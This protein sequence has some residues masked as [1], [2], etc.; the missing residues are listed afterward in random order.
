LAPDPQDRAV[1]LRDVS[2]A[3]PGRTRFSLHVPDFAISRGERVFLL[4]ESGSGKSTLLSLICGIVQ[5]GRGAVLVDGTDLTALSGPKR[6][7]LRANRIGV[8]FQMFNLLPYA[9]PLENILL[10]LAFA[11]E[12]RA[13]VPDPEAEALRLTAALGL[14]P[15]PMR[16]ARAAELSIGQQQRVA[17]ARA[18]IGGPHLVIADEPTS[19]LDATAQG[20]FVDLLMAQVSAAGAT[21]LMVSHDARLADRF[22]RVVDMRDIATPPRVAA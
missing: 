15:G 4:G 1:W 10:A 12:R 16:G 2:F 9:S 19:A 18:L 6:D 21:L 17:A 14:E 11:P 8:I 13:R 3:W 7:R 22:D 5:P 20:A